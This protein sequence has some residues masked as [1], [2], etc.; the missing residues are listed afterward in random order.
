MESHIVEWLNLLVRWIHFIVGVAWIGA[1]F[2]FNWL[3]NQLDRRT[4]QEQGIAGHLW[5]VHGGGFYYLKKFQVAPRELPEV[6]HWFKWEAYMT[7]VSGMCL[8]AVVYYFN[9]RA[10]LID[11]SVADLSPL[12]AS[13]IGLA[14]IILSWFV[15][16][17]LCKSPLRDRPLLLSAIVFLY[18]LVLSI[19]LSMLFSGRGA[20][21]HVG[22]AI[23]TIM[24]ANVFFV[25]IPGQRELVDALVENRTPD[26]QP[27]KNGLL[28]SRHNNYLTL[29]VLFIMVSNHF[30]STY[31]DPF[32]W[33]VLAALSVIGVSVRHYFN[34]RHTPDKKVWILPTALLAMV[35]MVAYTTPDFDFGDSAS[36]VATADIRPIVNQRC[37]VCHSATPT[38]PGFSSAPGGLMFDDD[39]VLEINA[40]RVFTATVT[41][42]IMPPGNLSGMTEEERQKIAQWYAAMQ[43]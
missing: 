36:D 18:L 29:P 42:K 30:P 34:I 21:I 39:Q 15:Y 32:N 41:S 43:R 19:G 38:Q 33:F 24:V 28:R 6:L 31:G 3:E 37:G 7:W 12:T 27:G 13:A 25:I 9:A 35:L 22:A 14:A 26:P 11:S 16:D 1:S 8:L 17:F 20:Y 2:Y 5:A 40:Q 4:Q 10:Y 23:G